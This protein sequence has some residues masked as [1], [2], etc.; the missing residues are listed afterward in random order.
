MSMEQL[1]KCP[2]CGSI[3]QVF[4]HQ[5]D[6]KHTIWW[7][8]CGNSHCL[9]RRIPVDTPERAAADWNQRGGSQ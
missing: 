6:R 2:F 9:A 7:I 1:E 4:C 5:M 8:Q 3:A